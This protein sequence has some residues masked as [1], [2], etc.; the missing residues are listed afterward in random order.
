MGDEWRWEI[1]SA[2]SWAILPSEICWFHITHMDIIR[3]QDDFGIF[4]D[5]TSLSREE[6]FTLWLCQ[7]SYWKLPFIVDLPLPINM[8]IFNSYVSLP[9]GTGLQVAGQYPLH[10]WYAMGKHPPQKPY[11]C[12]NSNYG[13]PLVIRHCNGKSVVNRGSMGKP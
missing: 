9:E 8:L 2:F 4:H 12:S 5:L 6:R 1:S 7:N 10:L 13:Y 11:E 3:R